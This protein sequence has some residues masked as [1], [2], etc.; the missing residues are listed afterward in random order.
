MLWRCRMWWMSGQRGSG[1]PPQRVLQEFYEAVGLNVTM[2]PL[3]TKSFD[4]KLL[5]SWE[6]FSKAIEHGVH[7]LIEGVSVEW[8]VGTRK[9]SNMIVGPVR[10]WFIDPAR[11]PITKPSRIKIGPIIRRG[12][13]ATGVSIY[14]IRHWSEPFKIQ[15]IKRETRNKENSQVTQRTGIFKYSAQPDGA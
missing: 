9:I 2:H 8:G 13:G 12:A 6:C 3:I 11:L 5:W 1:Q 14:H 4:G 7:N 10:K 15:I